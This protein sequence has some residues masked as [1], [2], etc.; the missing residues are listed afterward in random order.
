MQVKSCRTS[1]GNH[2]LFFIL[3]R[4]IETMQIAFQDYM[5]DDHV[6][7]KILPT[8]HDSTA[9]Y[10]DKVY[11][12]KEGIHKA[13]FETSVLKTQ[14]LTEYF[15]K[16]PQK[17]LAVV[18]HGVC[19]RL[20]SGFQKPGNLNATLKDKNS[21][22]PCQHCYYTLHYYNDRTW[23]FTPLEKEESP[24]FRPYYHHSHTLLVLSLLYALCFPMSYDCYLMSKNAA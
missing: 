19:I 6:P 18:T 10:K 5:K 16:V 14:Q 15:A 13:D 20:F 21:F 17:N 2:F 8:L 7:L 22:S 23:R 3:R 24:S 12:K 9:C 1:C 11:L 4:A